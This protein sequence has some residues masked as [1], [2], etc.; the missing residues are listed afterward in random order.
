M[1]GAN[2]DEAVLYKF[3]LKGADLSEITECRGGHFLFVIPR[4][5][6]SSQVGL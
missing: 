1:T 4:R 2:L 3:Q 6:V 5:A